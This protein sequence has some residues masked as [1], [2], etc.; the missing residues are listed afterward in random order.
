MNDPQT[1]RVL[2]VEDNPGDARLMREILSEEGCRFQVHPVTTLKAAC[3]WVAVDACDVVLLDLSLPDSYGFDTITGMREAAPTLPIIVLTGYDDAD[4]AVSAVEAGTQDFLVKGQFESATIRRTIRYAITRRTLEERLKLS[5]ERLKGIIDLAHDAIV[6]VGEDQR[7][8]L[9]NP[10]A[11][12]MF[13]YGAADMLGQPLSRL[14]PERNR[15]SHARHVEEFAAIGNAS[16]PMTERPVVTGLKSDGTEFPAEISISQSP[17]PVG[18][19][20]TA[21]IRDVTER[22]RVEDELRRLATTDP[23]TG[24]AN[25]RHFLERAQLELAR[26]K[27]YGD[28]V[29]ILMMDIDHFKR[30][31]DSRGHAAGD[32]ALQ[33]L[34]GACHEMLRETDLLGR[35]GGEE[36]AVLL[37]ETTDD[38]AF[39]V[40]E[41]LRRGLEALAIPH[42][43]EPFHFTV[44]I[45]LTRCEAADA[46]IEQPIARADKGLYEAKKEGRNRTVVSAAAQLDCSRLP[47][48]PS[49][50][51]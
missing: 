17:T 33:M 38:D 28:P 5:E 39:D 21:V 1:I 37:P 6:V 36:F 30:V 47:E 26:V 32:L 4:F 7:I 2:L 18:R 40:A 43:P 14:L 8:G 24:A 31:N 42:D 29:S 3:D 46:G 19:L 23:L 10:A 41:R 27:R 35:L 11:E 13:G 9:F 22:K 45:G 48:Y 50:V 25:R 16:R 15:P 12:R 49:I 20:F 51:R 44:S 34:V